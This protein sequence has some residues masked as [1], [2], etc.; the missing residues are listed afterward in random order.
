MA[1]SKDILQTSRPLSHRSPPSSFNP[2]SGT[3]GHRQ[4][5]SRTN[6]H[7]ISPSPLTAEHRVRR[8]SLINNT[9]NL[10][11]VAAAAAGVADVDK[12]P[13]LPVAIGPRRASKSG[14]LRP[15]LASLSNLP[16]HAASV[17]VDKIPGSRTGAI[18]REDAVDDQEEGLPEDGAALQGSR[19]RRASDGQPITK[20]GRK[21][22]RPVIKWEHTEAWTYTSRLLISKHQ[23]VQILEAAKLLV[24][25]NTQPTT[26]PE[27]AFEPSSPSL[28]GGFSEQLDGQSSARTTPPPHMDDMHMDESNFS[29]AS[30]D[31]DDVRGALSRQIRK[32]DAYGSSF[33]RYL[34][35]SPTPGPT[36]G[37]ADDQL[38]K[39]VA[40]L[41]CSYNSNGGSLTNQLP[42]D[43]PPVPMVPAHFLGQASLGQSPFLNSFPSRAPE[44][45]TRGER[46]RNVDTRMEDDDDDMRSRSRSD[47]DDY[48]VFGQM[49]E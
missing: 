12:L 35:P 2:L 32:E 27:S 10:A 34:E 30:D 7:T 49:E 31:E 8:K 11:A 4:S 20:E 47:E 25:M 40:M 23:Q 22:N 39:A 43:I 6:S 16:S 5:H 3:N 33:R 19:E 28:S 14:G 38:A 29:M 45:F 15:D 18:S 24:E 1:S 13:A 37:E 26:P 36:S 42:L 46:G 41:S 44:S 9:T 21:F 48:G 17:P